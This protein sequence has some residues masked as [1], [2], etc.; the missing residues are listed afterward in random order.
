[1]G[2]PRRITAVSFEE[3]LGTDMPTKVPGRL[4]WHQ[5]GD[6]APPHAT[7]APDAGCSHSPE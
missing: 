4:R 7:F 5:P 6:H 1:M 2:T 3:T